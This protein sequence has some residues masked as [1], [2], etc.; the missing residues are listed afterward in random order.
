MTTM[1]RLS[2]DIVFAATN[3]TTMIAYD[4]ALIL[5]TMNEWDDDEANAQ[6]KEDRDG[7]W[8]Y[9]DGTF[10]KIANHPMAHP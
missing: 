4:Q 2:D 7:Q 8:P 3:V 5:D 9:Y 10:T 1:I 6:S